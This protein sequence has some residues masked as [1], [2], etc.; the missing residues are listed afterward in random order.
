MVRWVFPA[1]LRLAIWLLVLAAMTFFWVSVFDADS[2]GVRV[3]AGR[4]ASQL[5]AWTAGR[6]SAL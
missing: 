6:A 5:F 2:D 4:N 3:S 1:I